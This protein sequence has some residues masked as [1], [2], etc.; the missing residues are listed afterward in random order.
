M[1][2]PPSY[3]PGSV[4][5]LIESDLVTPATRDALQARLRTPEVMSPSFF[6]E[7]AF[8][9][10]C[11]VCDRL[12]PQPERPRPIDLCGILDTRLADGEGDGWR[13][14]HM[15]PDADMHRVGIVGVEQAAAGMFGRD[16][17]KLADAAQDDVLRAI[18]RGAA[19]GSVWVAMDP[20]RYFEE[21]LAEVVD[22][23]YAHPLGSEEIGYA[24]MADAHGWQHIGLGEHEA[25]EPIAAD[26]EA[27]A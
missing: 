3:P 14:A 16:F 7:H 4:R 24:G 23:Y 25:H 19:G 20:V 10:L 13:F 1:T 2:V 15:P 17:A 8:A 12:I 5:M 9:T 18:Q 22:I 26:L 27:A 11:A 6:D 21:L